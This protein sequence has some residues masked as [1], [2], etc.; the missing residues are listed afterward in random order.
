MDAAPWLTAEGKLGARRREGPALTDGVTSWRQQHVT[1]SSLSGGAGRFVDKGLFSRRKRRREHDL[2]QP[3]PQIIGLASSAP[4]PWVKDGVGDRGCL[5]EDG[6]SL[7]KH[8]C[9]HGTGCTRPNQRQTGR[10]V[11]AGSFAHLSP[12][13]LLRRWRRHRF[14]SAQPHTCCC[15]GGG[16]PVSLELASR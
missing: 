5:S 13:P 10:G 6:A 4:L 2:N 12:Q 9:S 8:G 11:G 7:H 14:T 3:R 15:R 16:S 1:A